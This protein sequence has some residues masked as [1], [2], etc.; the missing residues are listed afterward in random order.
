MQVIKLGGSIITQKE[1][2]CTLREKQ[3]DILGATLSK[4]GTPLV[5]THGT[6]SFGKPPAQQYDYL[7]GLVQQERLHI[8]QKVEPLLEL[9][10]SQV[11]KTFRSKGLPVYSLHPAALFHYVK[12]QMVHLNNDVLRLTLDRQFI[13]IISG[14]F[15]F[16]DSGGMRVGSS[17][18]LAA[19]I[20][21]QQKAKRL[22]FATDSP[23]KLNGKIVDDISYQDIKYI[24]KVE[25]DVSGGMRDKL[26]AAWFAVQ[27]GVETV[28]LDGGNVSDILAVLQGDSN[29]GTRVVP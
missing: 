27:N 2:E 12:G 16:D 6:G 25:H 17:D 21:V 1:R 5:I 20:A 15:L 29:L 18:W 14:G 11:V 7:D 9:L 4:V 23:V 3:L 8:I 10:H 13:P 24:H 22:I 26:E 28:L 19:K